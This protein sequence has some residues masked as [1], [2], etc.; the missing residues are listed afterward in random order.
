[1][2][3]LGHWQA[4]VLLGAALVGYTTWSL[5][6][7]W[8]FQKRALRVPGEVLKLIRYS[9]H[10]SYYIRYEYAEA[11]KVAE[12]YGP[13]LIATFNV[14]D[15]LDILV[16]PDRLPDVKIPDGPHVRWSRSGNCIPADS[17]LVSVLDIAFIAGGLALL[18]HGVSRSSFMVQ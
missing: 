10:I 8:L 12:Y 6:S 9:K 11:T 13:S 16:D 15:H 1:M 2:E 5:W 14:G 17:S 7:D 3:L 18:A 4:E